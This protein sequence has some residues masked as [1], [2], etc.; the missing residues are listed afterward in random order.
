MTTGP[1]H[2]HEPQHAHPQPS[3]QPARPTQHQDPYRQPGAVPGGD[4]RAMTVLAHLSAP[5]AAVLSL[6]SLS[7]LGPLVIWLVYKDRSPLV[8]QAAA[9]AFNFN[10]T[11]W[12][13]F[14]LSWLLIFTVI[15]ALV[16]IPLLIVIFVVS[17]VLHLVG[18]ARGSKGEMFRY[19][20]QLP[21][22]S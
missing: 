15:G 13:L 3:S 17:A 6:G 8:R 14:L 10:L 16:G 2:P 20:F 11:F 4:D 9:G 1:Q 5:I 7:V 21:V 12:L 18:A 19:P 22:L